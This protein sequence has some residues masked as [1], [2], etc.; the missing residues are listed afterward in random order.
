MDDGFMFLLGVSTGGLGMLYLILRLLSGMHDRQE[1][2]GEE[3]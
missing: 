1:E 3:R 2:R